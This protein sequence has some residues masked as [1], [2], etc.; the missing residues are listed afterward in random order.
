MQKLNRENFG[1]PPW[2]SEITAITPPSIKNDGN[3]LST[4][5]SVSNYPTISEVDRKRLSNLSRSDLA[6]LSLLDRRLDAIK[7][8]FQ[9]P[10]F[11]QSKDSI[12]QNMTQD[13]V[14]L[15]ELCSLPY[16]LL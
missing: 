12:Q 16:L 7:F 1:W 2:G 5:L 14:K 6:F 3:L 10:N 8:Q 4:W 9:R 13:F 15:L 11:Q